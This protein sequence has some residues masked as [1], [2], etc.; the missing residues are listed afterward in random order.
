LFFQNTGSGFI[1][2]PAPITN[3]SRNEM[4]VWVDFDNDGDKDL[5]V[6]SFEAPNRLYENDGNLNLT[7]ITLSAGLPIDNA[8]SYGAVF[9][10]YNNDGWLDLY[11]DNWSYQGVYTNY[12]YKNNGD[13]TFSDVTESAGVADDFELTFMSAFLDINNNGLQD[14]YNSQDRYWSINSMFKNNGDDT[15]D[16][17]SSSSNTDIEIDAMN[18]GV[19]D[20]DNDGDLDIYVTNISTQQ[21]GNALLRNNGDETFTDVAGAMG[22]DMFQVTWGGNFFDADNDLDL[23]LYVSAQH[24]GSEFSSKLFINN[25]GNS[26][27]EANPPGMQGDTMNSYSNAIGDFNLDGLMDIVVN[28]ATPLNGDFNNFHLWQNTS[29]N[30]NNWLKVFL[31]GTDSNR[32]GIGSWIEMYINGN[33]YVRYKHCGIAYLAQNSTLEHFGMGPFTQAD[34]VIVRWLSGNAD[35][36]YDVT[37]NQILTIVE[38]SSPLINC[39]NANIPPPAGMDEAICEGDAIPE[40]VVTADPGLEVYWYGNP[41]GGP[42]LASSTLVYTPSGPGTYWTE[43]R[44]PASGC[45]SDTRTPI[46]LTVNENPSV[47]GGLNE[48]ACLGTPV[49]FVAETEG[50]DGNYSYAWTD[51]LSF[52]NTLTVAPPVHTSYTV[53]VTDG[54]GC[55][56]TDVV[57]AVVYELPA[58]T[59]GDDATI[60]DGDCVTLSAIGSEGQSPYEY[61]WS[62]GS[63]EVCP[64]TTTTYTVT[65]T[66]DNGCTATDEQTVNVQPTPVADAGEDISLCLNDC[67]TF[68]PT[69]TGGVEPYTFSWSGDEQETVCPEVTTTYTLDGYRR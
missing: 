61:N 36:L 9:G 28:N 53:T 54:N 51:G 7:D 18:V 41:T 49:T 16:D 29:S 50:G 35:V 15:F 12:L 11:L 14:L 58:V 64:N 2:I 20:Y 32:D 3:T 47:W 57:T 40:L 25:N 27:T 44:D 30:S 17:I 34:S 52:T 31:V 42:L 43:T 23:D 10:D 55:Q 65:V 39:D 38:G 37:A 62:G 59:A 6:T 66:D 22:V 1:E 26:F 33:K 45:S 8:P 48:F 24:V 60:C 69:A 19:G 56:D 21:D 63:E 67:F 4:V 13:G 68:N 46:T 5:F